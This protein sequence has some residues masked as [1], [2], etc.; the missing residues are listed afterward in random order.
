[1]VYMSS[2]INSGRGAM[3]VGTITG[4]AAS[5][6]GAGIITYAEHAREI[7]KS[8]HA[9][10]VQSNLE[11]DAP[12]LGLEEDV[13]YEDRD[14]NGKLETYASIRFPDTSL[15]FCEVRIDNG[16]YKLIPARK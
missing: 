12:F 15:R 5:V 3:R 13:M 14:R 8:E 1:M 2:K 10:Y 7:R 16:S 11:S 9:R 6:I 4:I